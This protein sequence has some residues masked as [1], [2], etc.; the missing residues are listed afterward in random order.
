MSYTLAF[1]ESRDILI[2]AANQNFNL[3]EAKGDIFIWMHAP[4]ES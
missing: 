3:I 1:D 2:N 4:C